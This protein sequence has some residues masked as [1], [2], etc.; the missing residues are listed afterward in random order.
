MDITSVRQSMMKQAADIPESLLRKPGEQTSVKPVAGSYE[1]GRGFK[2]DYADHTKVYRDIPPGGSTAFIHGTGPSNPKLIEKSRE[3]FNNQK[4]RYDSLW[5][6]GGTPYGFKYNTKAKDPSIS[7]NFSIPSEG[8]TSIRYID[9]YPNQLPNSRVGA[10]LLAP[11]YYAKQVGSHEPGQGFVPAVNRSGSYEPGRSQPFIPD[12]YRPGLAGRNSIPS[13]WLKKPDQETMKDIE[14]AVARGDVDFTIQ[15][16]NNKELYEIE[17]GDPTYQEKLLEHFSKIPD[18]DWLNA[19]L[20]FSSPKELTAWMDHVPPLVTATNSRGSYSPAT[21]NINISP[22]KVREELRDVWD[23]KANSATEERGAEQETYLGN[24]MTTPS[25]LLGD[26]ADTFFHENRHQSQMGRVTGGNAYAPGYEVRRHKSDPFVPGYLGAWNIPALMRERRWDP[27]FFTDKQLDW[28]K[29]RAVQPYAISPVEMDQAL[30]AMNAGRYALKQDM[31]NKPDNP[32]YMQPDIL[33]RIKP[34][35]LEQFKALPDF[36]QS[37]EEGKKQLDDMMQLFTE[38]PELRVLMPGGS[39]LVGYYQNLKAAVDNAETPE[40]KQYF[41]NLMDR[42]IYSKSF[43][44]NNQ[45]R[46]VPS[47]ADSYRA[48]A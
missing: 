7:W 22:E 12:A 4:D 18:R 11:S 39:R 48:Y 16:F 24:P 37:G 8:G 1:P 23:S 27:L 35:V 30:M 33:R 41:Q 19:G 14:Q 2:P 10:W 28:I 3:G 45:R 21:G 6:V 34:E 20:R 38:H 40:E 43:L 36:I 44:A 15:P 13:S 26:W 25:T 46:P 17:T 9:T 5:A 32:N 31:I 47:Y 42:L 29:D